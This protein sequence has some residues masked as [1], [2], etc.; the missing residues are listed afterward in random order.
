MPILIN[1]RNARNLWLTR[2]GLSAPPTGPLDVLAIIR[3]LGF[4]QLDTI[5][6]IA[7]AQHHIIWS[8]NQHYREPMLNALLA[9]ERGI[10]EHFTHDAS[11]IPMEF[12]PMWRRQFRRMQ[13]YLDSAKW[14]KNMPGPTVRDEIK[15]RIRLEGPLSTQA[16][17]T[18]STGPKKMWT[19]PPHKLALDYMWYAGELATSHRAGFTKHYDLAERIFPAELSNISHSDADQVNWLCQAAL[20]RLGVATAN[21]LKNF[22][23][24]VSLKEARDWVDQ[25]GLVP[26]QVEA[27]DGGYSTAFAPADISDQLANIK[28]ATSRLRILN[29]FDPAIRDRTRLKRLFGFDYRVEMF[30]PAAKRKWGYYVYPILQGD[31][32]IGRI[33]A[34]SERANNVLNVLNVWAEAGV[35]WTPDRLTKL[36]AELARLARFVGVTD[37]CWQCS[38]PA[39]D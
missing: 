14:N 4:V 6:I 18:K 36:T 19:R 31:R 10:F 29:P 30:V 37:I 26:V 13:D 25:T 22:W 24:A 34:K 1:N 21:E 11:V 7:R 20:D 17:D 27:A 2:Q 35:R 33:E 38:M 5:Q 32:F 9:Q 39:P 28:P 12:Y 3:Q 23:D 15:T 16:F 8:R